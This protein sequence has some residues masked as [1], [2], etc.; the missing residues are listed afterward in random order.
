MMSRWKEYKPIFELSQTFIQYFI[1]FLEQYFSTKLERRFYLNFSIKNL[2][3]TLQPSANI[4][5]LIIIITI[6]FRFLY[7]SM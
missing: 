6:N 1:K 7:L 5:H 2:T 4:R 3:Q